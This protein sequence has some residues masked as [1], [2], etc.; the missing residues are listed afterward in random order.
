MA[1]A[2]LGPA[3]TFSEEAARKFWGPKVELTTVESLDTIGAML[4]NRQVQ[5]ALAP[6]YNTLT[7]WVNPTLNLLYKNSLLIKG[8]FEMPVR[9]HLM[10]C[11]PCRLQEVEVI[12]SHP[13]AIEQCRHFITS[14]LGWV[15]L[16][17]CASTAGAARALLT[18]PRRAASISSFHAARNYGLKILQHDI[19]RPG[20]VTRFVHIAV[21]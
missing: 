12:I 19:N 3:G 2:V 21:S 15:E 11:K 16:Q 8:H 7:G 9:Q 13:L 14:Q 18:E 20:N 1:Y 4:A 17:P 5:G 6:L 10:V